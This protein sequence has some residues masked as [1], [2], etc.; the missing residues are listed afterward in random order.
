MSRIPIVAIMLAA[1]VAAC[2]TTNDQK[3]VSISP[4]A[5]PVAPQNLTFIDIDAF[6]ADLEAALATGAEKVTVEVPYG[7][8]LNDIPDR[9]GKW[10][11]AISE[12]DGD[13]SVQGLPTRSVVAIVVALA[14]KL[15]AATSGKRTGYRRSEN[16][17]AVLQYNQESGQVKTVE[18]IRRDVAA[19][20][21]SES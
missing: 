11:S 19:A 13:V 4:G 12:T 3:A 18:F 16:Y 21:A 2:G 14:V 9:M 20:Q 1:F 7:F 10:L 17:S 15:F 6:D 5:S 8:P